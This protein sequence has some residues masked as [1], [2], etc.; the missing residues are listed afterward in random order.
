MSTQEMPSRTS[1][2]KLTIAVGLGFLG[3]AGIAL[4]PGGST[5]E[6]F[7]I[8]EARANGQ[9]AVGTPDGLGGLGGSGGS[10]GLNG[11]GGSGGLNGPGTHP[12][13]VH[14]FTWG[15]G[16]TAL[17]FREYGQ[18][19]C[20][21]K[22]LQLNDPKG[23]DLKRVGLQNDGNY[24]ANPV[25]A[26]HMR[27]PAFNK[28]FSYVVRDGAPSGTSV[29]G[30]DMLGRFIRFKGEG[31]LT[32]SWL[33]NPLLREQRGLILGALSAFVNDNGPMSIVRACKSCS[34][35]NEIIANEG[36]VSTMDRAKNPK[37]KPTNDKSHWPLE[38]AFV[39]ECNG[40]NPKVR[41]F[42]SEKLKELLRPQAESS[43]HAGSSRANSVKIEGHIEDRMCSQPYKKQRLSHCPF[44]VVDKMDG[45][46]RMNKDN[47]MVCP[48]SDQ[49]GGIVFRDATYTFI[50]P[51]TTWRAYGLPVH[52]G[53]QV[54]G[55]TD[56]PR[57]PTDTPIRINSPKT[58]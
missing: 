27:E 36:L 28:W 46:C 11:S 44:E 4:M 14:D 7:G 13:G 32:F 56:L 53:I 26:E 57:P 6:P 58:R 41:I 37:I 43:N 24:V 48:V 15:N 30:P 5:A 3:A 40:N 21:N 34:G 18:L 42:W 35:L 52:I 16:I 55:P 33:N 45:V 20:S 47:G 29:V 19:L 31:G 22:Y 23:A 54:G 2:F 12:V 39:G 1:I 51:T 50:D 17:Q 38:L 10:G 9:T 8:R 25:F 49:D